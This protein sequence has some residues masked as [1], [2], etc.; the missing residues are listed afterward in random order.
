LLY[1]TKGVEMLS[2]ISHRPPGTARGARSTRKTLAPG[3]L[4]AMFVVLFGLMLGVQPA[5]SAGPFVVNTTGDE[6]DSDFPSGTFDGSSDGTCDVD[7][8]TTGAQCTLRAAIQEANVASGADEIHFSIPGSGA[9]TITPGTA[10]PPITEQV[11]IDGYTQGDGTPADT[12]DDATENTLAVGNNAVLKIELDGSN[13]GDGLTIRTTGSIVKGLIINRFDNRTVWIDGSGST[14]NKVEG[15]YIGTDAAGTADLGNLY[16]VYIDGASNNTVGGTTVAARNVISGNLI[17][18]SIFLAGA[19]GNQVMGN[20]VGTD[21]NGSSA[22]GN[23]LGVLINGGSNNTVGGT[24]AGARN[25]ISGN[26]PSPAFGQV[27]DGVYVISPGTSNNKVEGNYIG[28]DASGTGDLGNAGSGVRIDNQASNNTV[29]GTEAGARNIISGNGGAGAFISASATG[30]E[31]MGNYIGTDASGTQPLGNTGNGVVIRGASSTGNSILSNSISD[32][33][34]LGIDLV[35]GDETT[36]GVTRNDLKDPDRGANRLQNF[37][38]LTSATTASGTTTINGSLSSRPRKTFT[39]QFFS[40]PSE[41][42]STYGEGKTF[43]GQKQIMTS[44]DGKR[45]FAFST[46]LPPGQQV[47][48]ATAT[49]N[50][51][52]DTSEFSRAVIAN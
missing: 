37:P 25:I 1:A 33:G 19:T 51:T 8:G 52:G 39:I 12:S 7:S 24:E 11:T 3:L 29:G 43:L 17:G 35:G 20:Y 2:R 4:A 41:D 40:S 45:S 46:T 48:T 27:G 36:F 10:L 28:T 5:H 31:V 18:V 30:N 15:N 32:N 21:K 16:G 38:R 34:E 26:T 50:A 13:S 47:V 22:L 23:N 9:H 14:G 44:R 42:A 49:N 6:D